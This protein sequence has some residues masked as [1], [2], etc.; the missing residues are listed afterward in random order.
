MSLA[1]NELRWPEP[2]AWMADDLRDGTFQ[3]FSQFQPDAGPPIRRATTTP[4][5]T[6]RGTFKLGKREWSLVDQMFAKPGIN[7]YSIVLH[8]PERLARVTFV[9]APLVKKETIV[10]GSHTRVVEIELVEHTTH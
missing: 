1:L 6:L 3:A 4:V 2:L 9:K 8:K 5:P 10:D 7:I